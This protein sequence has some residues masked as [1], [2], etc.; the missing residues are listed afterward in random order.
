MGERLRGEMLAAAEADLKPDS[1]RALRKECRQVG[2]AGALTSS[3]SFGSSS[4]MS[5]A[6]RGRNG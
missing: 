3:S 6:C 2:G 5:E 4:C 1:R